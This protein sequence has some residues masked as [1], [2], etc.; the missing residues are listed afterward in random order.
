M[1][2]ISKLAVQATQAAGQNPPARLPPTA[3]KKSSDSIRVTI[4]ASLL[5]GQAGGAAPAGPAGGAPPPPPPGTGAPSMSPAILA[6][7]AQAA[8]SRPAGPAPRPI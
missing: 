6:Q 7:I 1:D 5:M 8:R 2:Q 3:D 4:P